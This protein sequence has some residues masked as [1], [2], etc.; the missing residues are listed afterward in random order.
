MNIAE[1]EEQGHTLEDVSR[2]IMGIRQKDVPIP[3]LPI[4]SPNARVFRTAFPARALIDLPC[5]PAE[6]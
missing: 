2:F 1:L 5:L 3:G 6:S 4:P